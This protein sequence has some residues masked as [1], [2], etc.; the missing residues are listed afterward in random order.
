LRG[1]LCWKI[2]STTFALFNRKW[3]YFTFI[4]RHWTFPGFIF[5]RTE[6]YSSIFKWILLDEPTGSRD[7]R[8][9]SNGTGSLIISI[10]IKLI[11]I[12]LLNQLEWKWLDEYQSIFIECYKY[13]GKK[14]KMKS[15]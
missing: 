1:D 7:K 8:W 4:F 12:K 10:Q 13:N 6:I 2:L 5:L 11:S 14:N 15:V 3:W 9:I